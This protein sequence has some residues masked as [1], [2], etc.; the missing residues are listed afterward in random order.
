MQIVPSICV[1]RGKVAES[2]QSPDRF[3]EGENGEQIDAIEY[4]RALSKKE[5]LIHIVDMDGRL[6][7]K[8]HL[9]LIQ[10]V[11]RKAKLWVDA[12]S[13][14]VEDLMDLLVSG[15]E[16][17]VL[18]IG[19]MSGLDEVYSALELSDKLVLAAD[20]SEGS[21]VSRSGDFANMRPE[22]FLRRVNEKGGVEQ[23]LLTAN[24]LHAS[25]HVWDFD[26]KV[27]LNLAEGREERLNAYSGEIVG[28][29]KPLHEIFGKDETRPEGSK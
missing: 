21:I 20:Y 7:G 4:V 25:G 28:E 1:S 19:Y 9:N 16:C 24:F 5:K 18:N 26:A 2:P 14:W 15:A 22:E 11:S 3:L 12:G 23:A 29:V 6:R 13:R 10:E 17:A 8:P 27:Y